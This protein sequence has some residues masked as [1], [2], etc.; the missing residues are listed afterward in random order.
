MFG[1]QVSVD[2]ALD[3]FVVLSVAV[4]DPFVEAWPPVLYGIKF[5]KFDS[6]SVTETTLRFCGGDHVD[7]VEVNLNPLFTIWSSL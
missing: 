5:C 7:S 1:S 6:L 3:K 2:V 4:T